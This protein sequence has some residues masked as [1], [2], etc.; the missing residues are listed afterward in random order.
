[1]RVLT[2]R[3]QDSLGWICRKVREDGLVQFVREIRMQEPEESD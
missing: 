1:M 2:A 3:E